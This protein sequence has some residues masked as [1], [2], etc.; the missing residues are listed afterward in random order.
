MPQEVWSDDEEKVLLELR[1]Q[2]QK[3]WEE[4]AK[5]FGRSISSCRGRYYYARSRYD[6]EANFAKVYE[7]YVEMI[8]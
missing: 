8:S 3:K 5:H 2:Q 7:R 1:H 4:I 6:K